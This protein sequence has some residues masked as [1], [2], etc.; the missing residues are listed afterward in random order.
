MGCLHEGHLSLIREV[1]RRGCL[2]VVSLFVNPLQFG[3]RE[4]F[5]RYPRPFES[6]LPALR[7]EGVAFLFAP[8]GGDVSAPAPPFSWRKPGFPRAFAA[9]RGPA[10]SAG[11]PPW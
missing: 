11:L 9:P 5:S 2:P 8:P 7:E 10:I 1:R 6:G 4:D 3:P